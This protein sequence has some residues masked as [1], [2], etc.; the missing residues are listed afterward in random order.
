M[1][2]QYRAAMAEHVAEPAWKCLVKRLEAV[3][4][5]FT[6]VWERHEVRGPEGYRKRFRQPQVGL[7]RLDYTSLWLGPTLGSRMITYI[8]VDDESARRL[9]RLHRLVHAAET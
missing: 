6:A 5:E 1:V 4:P 3:S 8:P 2:A 9:E 7:L